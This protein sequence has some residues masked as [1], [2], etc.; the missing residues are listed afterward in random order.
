MRNIFRPIWEDLVIRTV[1]E[2]FKNTNFEFEN[3]MPV[4][5]D[6]VWNDYTTFEHWCKEH[7]SKGLVFNQSLLGCGTSLFSPQTCCFIAPELA[8]ALLPTT[9]RKRKDGED[10]AVNIA[11]V[12]VSTRTGLWRADLKLLGKVGHICIGDRFIDQSCAEEALC[13]AKEQELKRFAELLH[14]EGKI[15][16]NILEAIKRFKYPRLIGL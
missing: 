7:Y 12:S 1:S 16:A 3:F 5:L 13:V 11:G 10:L 15:Y 4:E 14:D 8:K 2:F 6:E 9:A